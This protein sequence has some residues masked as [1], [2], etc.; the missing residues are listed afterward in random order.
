M[1][2]REVQ[3]PKRHHTP[4]PRRIRTHSPRRTGLLPGPAG[5]FLPHLREREDEGCL[6][7]S[8]R[9]RVP[10]AACEEPGTAP[11]NCTP[12]KTRRSRGRF[13]LQFSRAAVSV[14]VAALTV[15]GSALAAGADTAVGLTQRPQ[16]APTTRPQGVPP[17]DDETL[18]QQ[19]LAEARRTTRLVERRARV[20]QVFEVSAFGR[21]YRFSA[22]VSKES[23]R[24]VVEAE[25]APWFIPKRLQLALV[26]AAELLDA[27]QVSLAG[28]TF[29]ASGEPAWVVEAHPRPGQP[30]AR[31]VRLWVEQGSGLV[32]H[33]ELSY[34]W[35][36][37]VIDQTYRQVGPYTVLDLQEVLLKPLGIRIRVAYRDYWFEPPAS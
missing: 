9:P 12:V 3:D 36:T 5:P 15:V 6:R 4:A 7:A 24:I 1:Q 21:L 17:G 23:D 18:L 2:V 29:L 35:G 28:Q 30:G 33:L 31:R 25:D 8:G 16:A 11:P 10:R 26:E 22:L 14:C 13:G 20:R 27:Y 19:V 34:P 37:L 32:T